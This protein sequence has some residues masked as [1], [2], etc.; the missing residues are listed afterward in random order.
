MSLASY[1]VKRGD[2]LWDIVKEYGS[3]ISGNSIAAKIQTLVDLNGIK[4]ADLIITGQKLSFSGTGST[5]GVASSSNET[6]TINLFGL[7]AK[8][9]SGRAMYVTWS[10]PRPYTDHYT[11]KWR[12]YADGHW[13]TP[14]TKDTSGG[15]DEYCQD[16]YS[17]PAEA[18]RVRVS[19]RPVSQTF[20]NKNNEEMY[21]WAAGYCTEK[22]YN[23]AN[24]PPTAPSTPTVEINDLVLTASIDNIDASELNATTLE[25]EVVRDN[26]TKCN[27]GTAAINTA[28]NYVSYSCSVSPGSTYKVRCRAIRGSLVSGWSDYSSPSGTKPANVNGIT[29]CQANKHADGTVGVYLEWSSVANAT[30]YDIEYATDQSY[31]DG[32]D[33]TST[34]SGIEFNHYELTGLSLGQ[35]YFFRVRAV[36]QYG[37]SDWSAI[38]SIIIG[39]KPASPTTWSSTTTA[40]VGESVTL[41]WVH[42]SEDESTETYAELWLSI[43]G[44]ATSIMIKK[45][46]DESEKNKTSCYVINT[47]AYTSGTQISWKVRTRGITEDYSDWSIQRTIDVYANPT[48]DLSVTNSLGSRIDVLESFPF[49]ISASA[50]PSTQKPIGYQVKIVANEFYE[51]IDDAGRTK[52]VNAGDSIFSKYY[53]IATPLSITI[54]AADVDLESGIEYRIDCAVTMNTGLT[55]GMS[56]EFAVSWEEETEYT[57]NADIAIDEET[58]TASIQPYCKDK[59]GGLIEGVTLAVY[60][61]EFDGSFT[62]LSTGISNSNN[63]YITDPHPALNYAR[64]RIVATEISTGAI[65]FYDVPGYPVGGKGIV[66]Q[67]DEAWSEYDVD[68]EYSVEKPAWS[69]SML[70]LPYNVDVSDSSDKDVSLLSYAGREHPVS[71]YGTQQGVTATWTT[72]IPKSDVNTLYAL[73][74]LS[75]W[76]GDV[77][78]RESS[79]SGYWANVKVAFNQKH[80]DPTVPV[81]FSITRVEGGI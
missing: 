32:T 72:D 38:R 23:F 10:W 76:G 78:V 33:S 73:R 40:I 22:E 49:Y 29:T 79:G 12:Y 17:A 71:Y 6:V 27:S 45:S 20:K 42:N 8:D 37:N 62:Q 41:Y 43:N 5:T 65:S 59:F 52:M 1:I 15:S 48:L 47:A 55:A 13:H 14:D 56:H 28:T 31:F 3:S 19:I 57:L 80:N 81:S 51:T 50:G 9:T 4:D 11:V 16:T 24:N 7:Q 64:Y 25:F 21:F 30:S 53:D 66:M 74:R 26:T 18:E 34:K 35:E 2:T 61:R 46:T 58:L 44:N 70:R 39:K 63:T 75:I 68:D 69:G 36:N 54:T 60:R 77:Y 67:W